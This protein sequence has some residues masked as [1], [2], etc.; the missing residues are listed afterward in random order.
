M[1]ENVFSTM[2]VVHILSVKGKI[3]KGLN[4]MTHT[5]WSST[6]KNSWRSHFFL[7]GGAIASLLQGEEPNDW[8]LYCTDKKMMTEL[9]DTLIDQYASEIAEVNSKYM[10]ATVNHKLVT[11]NAV[12]MN[13]GYSFI[14]MMCMTP[15]DTKKTFDYLH[16]KPH[17]DIEKDKLYISRAQ[18]DACVNK[19]L[20]V[21]NESQ[22]KEYR[23]EKFI[24]RGY[25]V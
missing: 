2:E 5:S 1:S 20:V 23:T 13:G 15:A 17:Y 24:K 9:T 18:Y 25:T 7:S 8:D 12:T 4:G 6:L 22:I 10:D 14:R 19:K 11:A 3:S 21:N 16:C